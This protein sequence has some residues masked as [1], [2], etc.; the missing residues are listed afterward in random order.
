MPAHVGPNQGLRYGYTVG[1]DGW[2]PNLT[3]DM[4][5]VDALLMAKVINRTTNTP[6]GSPSDGDRYI[7]GGSPTG[8]WTGKANQIAVYDSEAGAWL[9]LVPAAG[10]VVYSA[11]DGVDYR[12][13]GSAW[14]RMTMINAANFATIQAA[15]DA[16]PAGGGVVFIPRGTYT[17]STVPAFNGITIPANVMVRGE[18]RHNTTLSLAGASTSIDAVRLAGIGSNGICDVFIAGQ[19]SAGTGRGLV[20][21]YDDETFYAYPEIRNLYID[22]TP[23]WGMQVNQVSV[24]GTCDNVVI[25]FAKSGGSLFCDG[26]GSVGGSTTLRF[27]NCLFNGPSFGTY[28]E[29]PADMGMVHLVRPANYVFI[30]C[31]FESQ[32]VSTYL[33]MFGPGHSVSLLGCYM[34]SAHAGRTQYLITASGS[35]A[36]LTIDSLYLTDLATAGPK[37]LK[38][39]PRT[40]GDFG[41]VNISLRNIQM[42]V[43]STSSS[44]DIDF[45]QAYDSL[46]EQQVWLSNV[47]TGVTRQLS[48]TGNTGRIMRLGGGLQ[49]VITATLGS[50]PIRL[51]LD[52][53][54]HITGWTGAKE[55][56]VAYDVTNHKL[57]FYDGS[58]WRTVTS[59]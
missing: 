18:S 10:W 57:M 24:F 3:A 30:G 37:F 12:W 29:E 16:V 56:D 34:E 38:T 35:I 22:S 50:A 52:T 31:N 9:F 4:K 32:S 6:P 8:A 5:R 43:K 48:W 25:S 42:I 33:S 15:I 54:A 44:D 1:E 36:N 53:N 7:V 21:N 11:A 23:S 59:T 27:T 13:N 26:D 17:P 58:A 2:G 45:N 46:V 55:G 51:P 14:G 19:N 28:G 49:P 47:D 39:D 40:D 41:V 20:V